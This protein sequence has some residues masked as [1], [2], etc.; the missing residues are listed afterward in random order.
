MT[1][2]RSIRLAVHALEARDNPSGGLFDTTFNGTAIPGA[3]LSPGFAAVFFVCASSLALTYFVV[4]A[5][6]SWT[7]GTEESWVVDF[8]LINQRKALTSQS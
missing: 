3:S 7:G 2:T 5:V 6:Q 1:R 8:E 4:L